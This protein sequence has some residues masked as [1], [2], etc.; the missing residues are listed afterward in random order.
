MVR[1]TFNAPMFCCRLKILAKT[2]HTAP[3]RQS[4]PSATQIAA[5]D[6]ANSLETLQVETEKY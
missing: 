2:A 1:R 4:K 5:A 3:A 6:M